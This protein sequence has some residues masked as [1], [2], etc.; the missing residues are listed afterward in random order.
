MGYAW[1]ESVEHRGFEG[2][3]QNP[4]GRCRARGVCGE[5]GA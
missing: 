5:G 1:E 3:Q 2:Y 4:I